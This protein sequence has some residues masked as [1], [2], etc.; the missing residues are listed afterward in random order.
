MRP[1]YGSVQVCF[2]CERRQIGCHADCEIYKEAKQK[3]DEERNRVRE[4]KKKESIVVGPKTYK[5]QSYTSVVQKVWCVR[6]SMKKL[7]I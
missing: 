5:K 3:S 2:D 7:Y 1:Y 6:C 4:E